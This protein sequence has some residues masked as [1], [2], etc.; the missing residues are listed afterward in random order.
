MKKAVGELKIDMPFMTINISTHFIKIFDKV[1]NASSKNPY[2][3]ND[4]P[5]DKRSSRTTNL[6]SPGM[7]SLS[8]IYSI[9]S[10]KDRSLENKILE[11]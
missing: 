6:N 8:S 2:K 5:S 9:S 11:I 7:D 3:S 10:D 4:P 1:L